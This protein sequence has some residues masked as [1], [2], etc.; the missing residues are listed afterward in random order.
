MAKEKRKIKNAQVYITPSCDLHLWAIPLSIT[1]DR[2]IHEVEIRF[3]CFGII[4][5][6]HYAGWMMK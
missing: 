3:L 6:Y 1:W 4:Y 2:L 5:D